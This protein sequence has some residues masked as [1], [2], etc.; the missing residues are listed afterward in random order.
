MDAPTPASAS[1]QFSPSTC[2]QIELSTFFDT[3]QTANWFRSSHFLAKQIFL[4]IEARY[5]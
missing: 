3:Q 2:E 1:W 5:E 4:G